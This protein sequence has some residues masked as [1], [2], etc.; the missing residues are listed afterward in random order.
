MGFIFVPLKPKLNGQIKKDEVGGT[1][2]TWE[3]RKHGFDGVTRRKEPL[4]RLR[5]R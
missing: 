5:Q 2:G 4:R 3:R 1:C